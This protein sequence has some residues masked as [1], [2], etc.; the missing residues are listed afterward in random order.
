M[1]RRILIIDD[2]RDMRVYLSRLLRKAGYETQEARDGEEGL[3][4]AK[5]G[6]AD[7]ITLDLVLPRKSGFQVY[8]ELRSAEATRDVPVIVV[9]GLSRQKASAVGEGVP[10]VEKPIDQISFLALVKDT[11]GV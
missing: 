10:V 11:V 6:G 8:K 3:E 7:L 4:M 5:D 2:E 1:A 9:T